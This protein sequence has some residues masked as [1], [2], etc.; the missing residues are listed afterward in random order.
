MNTIYALKIRESSGQKTLT[1]TVKLSI[2][3]DKSD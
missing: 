1:A 3:I 2:L